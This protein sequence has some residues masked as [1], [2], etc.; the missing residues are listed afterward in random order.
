MDKA[1]Y[2]ASFGISTCQFS[3]LRC[4]VATADSRQ[5]TRPAESETD[6]GNRPRLISLH[7]VAR[8]NEV[9]PNTSFSRMNRSN[10]LTIV[11]RLLL[12]SLALVRRCHHL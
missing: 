8:E 5:P 3:G 2:A 11:P 9:I 6:F 12:N 10:L 7:S 1:A 4:H